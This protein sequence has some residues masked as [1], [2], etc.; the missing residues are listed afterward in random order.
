MGNT[1]T[2]IVIPEELAKEIERIAGKRG[3]SHFLVETA[4]REVRR[5]RQL[6]ALREAAGAWKDKDHPE[7]KKGAAHW[8]SKIRRE[9]EKRFRKL[10]RR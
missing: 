9:E 6:Q 1:R 3:R 4:W 8:I 7:L 5:L 10:V 2:H